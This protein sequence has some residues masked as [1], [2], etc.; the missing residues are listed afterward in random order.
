MP[1]QEKEAYEVF[2]ELLADMASLHPSKYIHIGGDETY[3]LGHCEHCRA[4][5]EREGKSRLYVDYL[6]KLRVRS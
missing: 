6:R 1:A 5:A 4:K 3:L 2:R